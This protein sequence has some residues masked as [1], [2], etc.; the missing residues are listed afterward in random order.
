M[1][2]VAGNVVVLACA[3]SAGVHA[4]LT[5]HHLEESAWLGAG[6]AVAAVAL[7]AGALRFTADE[8]STVEAVAVALLL[9]A[10]IAGYAVSR[11]A[12]LPPSGEVEPVDVVGMATQAIQAGGL[13]ALLAA[14]QR[15][16]RKESLA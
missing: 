3:A 14:T 2:R 10:L 8:V 7:F 16:R 4:A 6:F 1:D 12:G 9:V 5:P 11:S 15:T 13:V